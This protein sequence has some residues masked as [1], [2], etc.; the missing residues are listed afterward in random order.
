[1]RPASDLDD[2]LIGST[3]SGRYRIVRGLGSGGFGT[4]YAAQN[5]ALGTE[6]AVKIGRRPGHSARILREAKAAAGLRSPYTVR[7]FDVGRVD[8]D[9]VY[10]VMESLKGRSLRDFLNDEGPLPVGTAAR[11]LEQVCSALREAHAQKLVHRDIKP[12]NLFVVEDANVETHIKLLDF[13]LAKLVEEN[14]MSDLTD[15]D[16]IVGSPLY[17]SPEQARS[18]AITP[19]SDIWSLGV[20]FYEMLSGRLPFQ[21]TSAGATLVAIAADPPAPIQEFVPGLPPAVHAIIARCL[22]K[23]PKERFQSVEDLAAALAS[24]T[25]SEDRLE[26]PRRSALPSPLDGE[27]T[28]GSV[29]QSPTVPLAGSRRRNRLGWSLALAALL[30]SAFA[31]WT[32]LRT[33]QSSPPAAS[34]SEPLP[35]PTDVERQ[36][37]AR[38]P[39]IDVPAPALSAS[40]TPPPLARP[41]P[42]RSAAT[43]SS[44]A[45][46]A[47]S[48]PKSRLVL[49]PDF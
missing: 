25:E 10:I 45:R 39:A 40:L 42:A 4:V 32:V 18:A 1:M 3:L 26:R 49:D 28:V 36:A 12:S 22:R 16:V 35:P 29:V 17:M 41:A 46:P 34:V 13:G 47:A 24:L 7:V 31:T 21:G 15:S 20:V 30:L 23:A 33:T 5:L 11:W 38:A 48:T 8:D 43:T 19:Q 2:P 14:A 44:S 37:S 27:S 6:V 9:S